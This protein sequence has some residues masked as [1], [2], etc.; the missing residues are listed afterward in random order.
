MSN[1]AKWIMKCIDCKQQEGKGY[2]FDSID[3]R[4]ITFGNELQITNFKPSP[5]RKRKP[6]KWYE[7]KFKIKL[8]K[9][10]SYDEDQYSIGKKSIVEFVS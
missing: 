5:K 8:I 9:C 3:D 2:V 4:Y 7:T 1:C 10:D 6:S